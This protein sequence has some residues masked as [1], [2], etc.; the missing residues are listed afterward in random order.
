MCKEVTV[1]IVKLAEQVE[2]EV[3]VAD[4][5]ELVKSH[6]AELSNEDMMELEAVKVAEWTDAEAEDEPAEEP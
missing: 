3:D 1:K 2:L 6:G 4:V 5:D